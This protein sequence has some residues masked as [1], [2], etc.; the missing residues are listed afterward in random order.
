[1]WVV[2]MEVDVLRR[3][4]KR[5]RHPQRIKE[6]MLDSLY[7]LQHRY[8]PLHMHC[9]LVEKGLNKRMS[10]SICRCYEVMVYGWLM[11][12]ALTGVQIGRLFKSAG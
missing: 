7:N 3:N 10:M 1:M 6:I 2:G 9:R 8:N 5:Q 12:L 4:A 11:W